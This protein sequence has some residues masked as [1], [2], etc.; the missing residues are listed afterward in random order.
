MTVPVPAVFWACHAEEGSR[1]AVN[2]FDKT[3]L[4]YDG[5]FGTRTVFYHL[6]AGEGWLDV[7]VPVL[8]TASWMHGFV[9]PVTILVV[10]VGFLWV[11]W[12]A[13]RPMKVEGNEEKDR[14]EK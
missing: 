6:T 2:P 3:G 8:D 1:F 10:V 14:K 12:A 7:K 9:E 4:G 5:L 13:L 11:C